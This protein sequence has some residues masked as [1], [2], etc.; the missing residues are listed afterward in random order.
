MQSTHQNGAQRLRA[1]ELVVRSI[2]EHSPL[3]TFVSVCGHSFLRASVP[4]VPGFEETRLPRL[5]PAS[6]VTARW[7]ASPFSAI[8]SVLLVWHT[9]FILTFNLYGFS[10][11]DW[12]SGARADIA[13]LT[14]LSE[15]EREVSP[16]RTTQKL[17][18]G[19]SCAIAKEVSGVRATMLRLH[20]QQSQSS[21]YGHL[22]NCRARESTMRKTRRTSLQAS[23]KRCRCVS[24]PLLENQKGLA[25]LRDCRHK[26]RNPMSP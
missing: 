1:C 13:V 2:P 14:V 21:K 22:L 5:A 12:H 7:S 10:C 17:P 9:C 25:G 20:E 26:L 19:L 8:T 3:G 16:L 24:T 6:N 11:T 4:A 15:N 18:K 23:Q